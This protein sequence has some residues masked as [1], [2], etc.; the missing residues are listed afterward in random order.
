MFM[1]MRH[2]LLG[3]LRA[4][5]EIELYRSGHSEKEAR[6]YARCRH[7]QCDRTM[8]NTSRSDRYSF[9]VGQAGAFGHYASNG[10]SFVPK[11]PK[12]KR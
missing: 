9:A 6:A 1:S 3:N 8:N 2:Y 7:E 5:R 12:K 10:A 4:D 11:Y